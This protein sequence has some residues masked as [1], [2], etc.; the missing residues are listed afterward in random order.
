MKT[1]MIAVTA[2][3]LASGVGAYAQST[4]QNTIHQSAGDRDSRGTPKGY[5]RPMVSKTHY[6]SRRHHHMHMGMHPMKNDPSI[7][8]SAGDRDSRGG[9][10]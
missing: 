1:V 2:I 8:Q 4:E 9:P 3:V 5:E 10:K 6:H 7:H